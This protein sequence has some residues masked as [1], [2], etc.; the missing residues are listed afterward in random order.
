MDI[1]NSS[2]GGFKTDRTVIECECRASYVLGDPDSAAQHARHH[3][4]WQREQAHMCECGMQK[5]ARDPD[6]T[7]F[8]RRWR[9]AASK[10]GY[11][12]LGYSAGESTKDVGRQL[13]ACART[14]EELI[15]GAR[16]ILQ[17]H[18]DRSL[19][20]SIDRGDWRKHPSFADYIGMADLDALVPRA[21]AAVRTKY[22]AC[23]LT[24]VL[25]GKTNWTPFVTVAKALERR[26]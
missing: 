7:A 6:H 20:H 24:G 23:P 18:F 26:E 14:A 8:H 5:V 22:P 25:D 10:L 21:A 15:A 13:V 3:A 11:V 17:A 9:R 4:T 1:F 16:M 19:R 2:T 12:P